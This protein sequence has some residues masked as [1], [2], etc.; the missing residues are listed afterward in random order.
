MDRSKTRDADALI[1]TLAEFRY[2]MRQ[3]LQFS[4]QAAL[5]AGLQAKQYQLLLQLAASP[6]DTAVTIAHIAERMGLKHNSAVELVDRCEAEG[7]VSRSEDS[8][9]RRRTILRVTR[10]GSQ[11]LSRLAGQHAQ[12]LTEAAPRLIQALERIRQHKGTGAE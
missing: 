9:D 11:V 4:E 12:E 10:K 1:R 5:K 7:L 8:A 2:E 6:E 3:F